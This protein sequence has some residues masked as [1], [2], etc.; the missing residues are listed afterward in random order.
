MISTAELASTAVSAAPQGPR[1]ELSVRAILTGMV[2]AFAVGGSYPYVVLKLGFGPTISVVSAFLA[3]LGLNLIAVITRKRTGRYEYNIV[4]TAGTAAGQAAFMCV[5][6]A[7]F[8]FL[9]AKPEL[10]FTINPTPF[11]VFIWM[12]VAGCLGVLLAVPLRKHYIDEENLSFPDGTVAGETLVILDSGGSEAK[13]RAYVLAGGGVFSALFTWLRDAAHKIPEGLD[14]GEKLTALRVGFEFSPMSFGSGLIVGL[15]ITLSM[16]LGM[17]LAWFIAPDIVVDQGW[18]AKKDYRSV[19][20]WVMW[21]GTGVLV[22]GGLTALALK[23]KV[24]AKT[25]ADLTQ[26][27]LTHGSDF[28]MRWVG[29]G[30]GILSVALIVIQYY[31][32][33]VAPWESVIAILISVVLMVV[34]IRVLGE[35]NWAPISSMANMVQGLFAVISPGSIGVNMVASGMS[36]TVAGAG[37]HLMQDYKAGKIIGSN[38]RAL[39]Y[40]QLL[41]TPV[42][43]LAIA[44]AYPL[45]K[46]RYGLGSDCFERSTALAAEACKGMPSPISVKWAGFAELL[47][48]GIEKLP[49]YSMHALAVA[50]VLGVLI[51]IFEEK[52]KRFLPSP[53]GVAL[54]MLVPAAA[55]LPML[56]GGIVQHVWHRVDPKS[57]EVYVVPIASGLVVGE[58]MLGLVIPLLMAAGILGGN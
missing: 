45:L 42:G 38:N 58:A 3:Y 57:E 7:A 17:V 20:T 15:R 34:G 4:Q 31:S 39:T 50:I 21:P 51:T 30:A 56:L 36:G 55:I 37:E 16:A 28:P 1:S 19:L 46:G 29:I 49:K 12:S 10:G 35:T 40:M 24:V 13:K 14:F 23:W 41:A 43:A 44:W 52:H 22:A 26:G 2:V 25:F 6:L 18:V 54:G 32:L 27:K 53:T 33:G 47:L 9:R 11:Q 8:D 48:G 5:V